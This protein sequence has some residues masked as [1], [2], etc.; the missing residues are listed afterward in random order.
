MKISYDKAKA[1]VPIGLVVFLIS[2]GAFGWGERLYVGNS[3]FNACKSIPVLSAPN[4]DSL[5]VG[6]LSFGESVKVR[7]HEGVYELPDS[8]AQSLARQKKRSSS[9]NDE[10]GGKEINPNSYK[11]PAWIGIGNN[12]FVIAACLV[13]A[14]LIK[15]Q[16]V[17]QAEAKIA[18][19][20]GSSKAKKG[21][22]DDE[23]GDVVVMK[24]AAGK[25]ITGKPQIGTMNVYLAGLFA[26]D[27]RAQLESFRME[28]KLG[29]YTK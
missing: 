3:V 15:K 13:D 22:T 2:S 23:E 27:T 17:E 25:A 28:G 20:K 26:V 7:S 11:R 12:K 1:V 18:S 5:V 29:E 14:D 4:P 19:I 9:R 16:N 24:G 6:Q 21:F 8:D 10:D